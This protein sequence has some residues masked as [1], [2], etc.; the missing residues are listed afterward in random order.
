RTGG[1]DDRALR[2]QFELAWP[3][4]VPRQRVGGAGAPPVLSLLRRCLPGGM[5]NRQRSA[6]DAVRG[7]PRDRPPPGRNLPTRPQRAPARVRR[8]R[9]VPDGSVLARLPAVL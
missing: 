2:R 8:R 4:V 3:R 5:P 1:V 7:R 6:A 9:A